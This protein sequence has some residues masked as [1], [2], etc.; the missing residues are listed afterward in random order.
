MRSRERDSEHEPHDPMEMPRVLDPWLWLVRRGM[1]TL[2]E[3][4]RVCV[5]VL[6]VSSVSVPIPQYP[7]A[8]SAL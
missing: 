6:R 5:K 3:T 8:C 1:R 4:K 7:Q 2:L